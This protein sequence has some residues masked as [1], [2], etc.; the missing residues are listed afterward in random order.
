VNC[1]SHYLQFT[2][3]LPK[4]HYF[5]LFTLKI[6]SWFACVLLLFLVVGLVRAFFWVLPEWPVAFWFFTFI[7]LLQFY[8]LLSYL[9]LKIATY[10]PLIKDCFLF[11]KQPFLL[12]IDWWYFFRYLHVFSHQLLNFYIQK[13]NRLFLFLQLMLKTKLTKKVH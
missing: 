12:I 3:Q 9:F 6:Y 4:L 2:Q 8:H 13:F 10:F 5:R 1:P 7:Q 11:F